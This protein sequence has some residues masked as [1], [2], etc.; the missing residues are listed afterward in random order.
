MLE[1]VE[2][3]QRQGSSGIRTS[4]Y[5]SASSISV[6]MAEAVGTVLMVGRRWCW[7]A[8]ECLGLRGWFRRP[9]WPVMVKRHKWDGRYGWDW[10]GRDGW[11]G[12]KMPSTHAVTTNFLT[13][14]F[15]IPCQVS[16]SAL[17]HLLGLIDLFVCADLF[18]TQPRSLVG[19]QQA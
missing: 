7:M 2:R 14:L 13:L 6:G 3:D 1:S 15:W 8:W 11:A 9:R 16:R 5:G 10:D 18:G 4:E 17:V 12:S 19:S